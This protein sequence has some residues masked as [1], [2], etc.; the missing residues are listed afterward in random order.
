MSWLEDE[1]FPEIVMAWCIGLGI[2]VGKHD[3][4]RRQ[5]LNAGFFPL[6]EGYGVVCGG[7]GGRSRP[8]E[9]DFNQADSYLWSLHPRA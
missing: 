6:L 3:G 4:L 2:S 8:V 1:F 7:T 5:S 9:L